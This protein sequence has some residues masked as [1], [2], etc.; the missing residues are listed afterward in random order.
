[1][2]VGGG[3]GGGGGGGVVCKEAGTTGIDTLQIVGSVRWV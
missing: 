2:C 3:G 1:L